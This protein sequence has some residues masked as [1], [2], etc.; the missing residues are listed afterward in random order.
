MGAEFQRPC[1]CASSI[2]TRTWTTAQLRLPWNI[3]RSSSRALHL[4]SVHYSPSTLNLAD[5]TCSHHSPS[6]HDIRSH[7]T[8]HVTYNNGIICGSVKVL[9][10]A[11]LLF[12]CD[13]V[14]GFPQGTSFSY[15]G[16]N[17]TLA[18]QSSWT[19]GSGVLSIFHDN[20][21]LYRNEA[22]QDGLKHGASSE[23]R[24]DGT[25]RYTQQY[26]QVQ[27]ATFSCKALMLSPIIKRLT[28][29]AGPEARSSCLLRGQ[30]P[31]AHSQL[32][33]LARLWLFNVVQRQVPTLGCL[34]T[35]R[36]KRPP[37][38]PSKLPDAVLIPAAPYFVVCVRQ[39]SSGESLQPA[40]RP[41]VFL[42]RI[43]LRCRCIFHQV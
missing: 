26:L 10:A 17:S 22:F 23:Y 8:A 13:F 11:A 6:P 39:L 36:F 33:V 19:T 25:L 32:H 14:D 20:S 43:S 28:A 3:Y 38:P 16:S 5:A 35:I 1:T 4:A 12:T 29:A 21:T 2:F 30:W 15:W 18:S 40:K 34:V 41:V 31:Y 7:T 9:A 42:P 27:A 24:R 37:L